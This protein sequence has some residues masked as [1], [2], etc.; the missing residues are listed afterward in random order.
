M[1][2]V[3]GYNVYVNDTK[4]N[5]ELVTATE[6]DLTGL[7]AATEY[8]VKVTAV[9]AAGNVSEKSEAATFTTAKAADTEAPSVPADVKAS[10][11]TKTGATVHGQLLQ[12]MK[13]L[14]IQCICKRNS[15]Q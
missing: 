8:S 10:D 14:R 11:V 9:D 1:L 15:G 2:A 4:V 6:Y 12:I 13:E 3:V 5:A 7:T